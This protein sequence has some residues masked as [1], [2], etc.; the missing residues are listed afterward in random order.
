[1]PSSQ[2]MQSVMPAQTSA[3][4]HKQ[5]ATR[6]EIKQARQFDGQSSGQADGFRLASNSTA[7]RS[8]SA[9]STPE[10]KVASQ[11]AAIAEKG[12]A[13]PEAPV[14]ALSADKTGQA[15]ANN[16]GDNT[17]SEQEMSDLMQ[18][19]FAAVAMPSDKPV[20]T[21]QALSAGALPNNAG[22]ES[23]MSISNSASSLNQ[24][25]TGSAAQVSALS[26]QLLPGLTGDQDMPLHKTASL[27]LDNVQPVPSATGVTTATTTALSSVLTGSTASSNGGAEWA[28]VRIDTQAGKWGEQM[29]QVLQ[30]RVT[31]QA[32]QNL[33]EAKI[34]LDP[35][36]LGKLDL[37]VRVEGDRLSVQIHA[38]SAATREALMQVSDRLRAEL[39]NQN[40][41]HVDVNV[42]S[43]RGGQP[44]HQ[45]DAQEDNTTTVFAARNSDS[46]TPNLSMSEHWLS[47][48]A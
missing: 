33:Q 25:T 20:M 35:P 4:Q 31:L 39:Q 47:T 15:D 8:G 32:Q 27:S 24:N 14:V 36:D 9:Q 21:A 38:N 34:R 11:Y 2:T 23:A 12:S 40:F 7:S 1:M 22:F 19:F 48:Q 37:T 5:S 44:Q 29:L 18:Q 3:A 42:G 41:V 6:S 30:D 17:D 45:S 16:D 26:S 43:E 10:D 28:S 46:S 13:L